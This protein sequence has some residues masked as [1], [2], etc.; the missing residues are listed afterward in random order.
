[1]VSTGLSEV[2]GSWKII[3]MSL[4]RTP[5]IVFFAQRQQIDAGKPDRAA[6][7]AAGRI[8]HKSHQGKRGDALAAA[9]FANDRQRLVFG[10]A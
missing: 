1:M 5:R 7:D 3:A 8:G 10:R 2:I 9:G 4:P 6:G